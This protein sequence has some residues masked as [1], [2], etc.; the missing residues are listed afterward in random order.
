MKYAARPSHILH[1]GGAVLLSSTL[2]G[3]ASTEAS[4]EWNKNNEAITANGNLVLERALAFAGALSETQ[5]ENLFQAYSFS[6]ASRW[7]TYPQADMYSGHRIGLPL[8]TLSS[9]QWRRLEALLA[10]A[11]GSSPNEG[12]DEIR[13]HLNAEDYLRQI[14]KGDA[15]GRGEFYVAFLGRPS[16]GNLW[17]LQFGGHHFALSNTYRDGIL[18]GATPS[19]RG[20]E[21]AGPFDYNGVTNAPQLQEMGAFRELLASFDELQLSAAKLSSQFRDVVM[22]PGRDWSFPTQAAGI[23]AA[24]LDDRQRTLLLAVIATYVGDV[25]DANAAAYMA[26]YERELATTRVGYSGTTSLS[27]AGDYVR[28]DGPSVWIELSLNHGYNFSDPHPHSVWR[29][30]VTDYG[31]LRP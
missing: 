5:R 11:S 30:K 10:A 8:E 25:D 6:N 28:I 15:Y 18:I 16:P 20:M 3:Y 13:Q 4:S 26:K 2:T 27:R 17:Q 31:G 14:G 9:E 1:F 29:D 12:S 7:H 24:S 19:F 23:P 21:P 22:G